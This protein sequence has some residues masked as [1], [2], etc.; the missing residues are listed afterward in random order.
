MNIKI[1]KAIR[2]Q[3]DC[4]EDS[5]FVDIMENIYNYGMENGFHGFIY[6]SENLTFFKKNKKIILAS[7]E[8]SYLDYGYSCLL[9]GLKEIK[10]LQDYTFSDIAKVIYGNSEDHIIINYLVWSFVEEEAR[11]FIYEK[12]FLE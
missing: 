2:S 1:Q 4:N 8:N 11:K 6:Y 9:T 5:D 12:E 10:Q 3:M 7:L